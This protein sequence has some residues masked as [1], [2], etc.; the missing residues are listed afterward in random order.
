MTKKV[1]IIGAGL[2]GIS[3]GIYLQQAGIQTEIY[4]LA[5]WA[6][7]V[8][9]TWERKG[10][11]FDGCIHWMVGTKKGDGFYELYREVDALAENTVIHNSEFID[12]EV[13]GE[14]IHLPM[15]PDRF[16]AFLLEL[17]PEDKEGIETFCGD[18]AEM[19]A[20]KMP[21]GVPKNPAALI[22]MFKESGGFLKIAKKY[23]NTTVDEYMSLFKNPILHKL[24]ERL[25]PKDFSVMALIMMLGTRMSGN[26]GY[27]LGGSLELIRRMESKYRSLGGKINFNSRVDEIV[28]EGGKASGIRVKGQV[29][30]SDAVIAACDAYDTLQKM[31]GGKYP[32]PQLDGM[33][34]N[35]PLFAPLALVSFGLNK[36]FD[37]PYSVQYECP[38]GIPVAPGELSH[39]LHLRSFEFDPASAPEGCSS[40]MVM[41]EAPLDYWQALRVNDYEEYK[42]QKQLLADE[43]AAVLEKRIPGIKESIVITDVSTPATYVRL[44]NLYKA[45]F[46]GF[47]P[48]IKALRTNISKTLPGVKGFAICGQWVN[49]GGGICSAIQSG[50][51][52]AQLIGKRLK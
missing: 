40:I 41:L 29:I 34:E 1:N 21:T 25:M 7:G 43:V 27:P 45:S 23:M 13:D 28:V 16:K 52:T 44:V 20:G 37:I 50:K 49:A 22:T 33:L 11:R 35:A 19:A 47:L 8:C 6:G 38:E 42:R 26:A 36:K 39:G 5:P 32:H 3:A 14:M 48:T 51:E 24:I 46:E 15:I 18:I 9:T 4:E 2:A 17:S 31:L 30:P 10:Y 12:I